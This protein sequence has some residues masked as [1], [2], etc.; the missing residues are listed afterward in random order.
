MK[1]S[2]TTSEEIRI[3]RESYRVVAKRGSVLYFSIA[4]KFYKILIDLTLIDPMY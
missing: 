1:L 3:A 4:G 2:K